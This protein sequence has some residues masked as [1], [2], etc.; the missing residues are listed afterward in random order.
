MIKITDL[1]VVE[2]LIEKGGSSRSKSNACIEGDTLKVESKTLNFEMPVSIAKRVFLNRASAIS[3]TKGLKLEHKL[4]KR[5]GT[6]LNL[7]I[8]IAELLKKL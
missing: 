5:N 1:K 2:G 3:F 6:D 7:E 8:R 4:G